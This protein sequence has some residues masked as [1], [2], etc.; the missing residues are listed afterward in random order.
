MPEGE[1][2]LP[3]R[4]RK[5][6][7]L[8]HKKAVGQH[9]ESQMPMESL[10]AASLVVIQAAFLLGVFIK[11]LDDESAHGPAA[12]GAAMRHLRAGRSHQ[13]LIFSFSFSC[14]A[15]WAGC[16]ETSTVLGTGRS[17]RSQPW[18]PV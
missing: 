18:G 3:W 15:S 14:G 10:P 4:P 16:G 12:Q 11:L 7:A 9:D 5:S 8:D 1:K 13:Y 17:A 6:K 2:S